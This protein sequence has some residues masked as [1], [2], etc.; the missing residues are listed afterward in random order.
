MAA[1]R[2]LAAHRDALQRQ[3]DA[4]QR[5]LGDL[6]R[7]EEPLSSSS[8]EL[9]EEDD[10]SEDS[11]VQPAHLAELVAERERVQ[12]EI[13]E[14]EHTLGPRDPDDG[15]EAAAATDSSE[16]DSGEELD[17]PHNVETCL[18]MNLVYQE[19][20]KE[21][22]V[23]LE[24]LLLDNREQQKKVMAQITG[25]VAPQPSSSAMSPYSIY[26]GH[27]MKPYFKDKISSLGPPPN[28]ETRD[29]M[30]KGSM[31][32]NDVKIKRWEGWH[33]TLLFNA[34]V[35]DTMKR[36]LQPK[37]SK[38]EYLTKKMSKASDME[39]QILQKQVG[40]IEREI[41]DINAMTTDQLVGNRHDDHDWDKISNIDFEGTRNAADIRRF[42]Q[43]C[44]H[45]SVN[46][47]LWKKDE[48]EKLKGIVE[49]YKACHWDQIAEKLGTNRTAFMCLQMYQR[50]INKGFRKSVWSKE[51]DEVLKEL[52]YKM[53]IGNFIPYTQ[54]SYFMEGRDSSQLIYRW[55]QVLDP[56]LRKG[57]WSKEEDELLLKAVAKYGMKDWAKIRTE[58]PGRTDGQCRDRYLDCLKG[59]VK[60]G[61]WSKEEDALL[62]KLVEKHGVGRWAK[63][64][65]ELPNRLDCQCLQRWKAMTGYGKPKRSG[66]RK[67]QR[68]APRKRTRKVKVKV[69]EEEEDM[70]TSEDEEQ[71]VFMDSEEEA[72]V[73]ED[74][75]END[76][77]QYFLPSVEEW[78]PKTISRF[79]Q[80]GQR[81]VR[82]P[83]EDAAGSVPPGRSRLGR[84][85]SANSLIRAEHLTGLRST[86]VDLSGCPLGVVVDSE[87][88][89]QEEENF[90]ENE[91]IKV[92]LREVKGLL[93]SSWSS[94]VI[95]RGAERK[96]GPQGPA[97]HG[98]LL[99]KQQLGG[100]DAPKSRSLQAS[101][102]TRIHSPA[103][104]AELLIAVLPWVGSLLV[105]LKS[106]HLTEAKVVR[107]KVKAIGLT[108]TPVFMLFLKVLCIDAEGCK[109]VIE[110]RRRRR[111]VTYVTLTTSGQDPAVPPVCLK[112]PRKANTHTVAQMLYEKRQR[113]FAAKAPAQPRKSQLFVPCVMV[114]QTVLLKP[115][116]QQPA[117]LASCLP[118][119]PVQPG[120][121][122]PKKRLH[123][124]AEDS[125]PLDLATKRARVKTVYPRPASGPCVPQGAA[126]ALSGSVTWIVTPNGLL[127]VS[128]LGALMPAVTQTAVKGGVSPGGGAAAGPLPLGASANT[129]AGASQQVTGVSSA[130]SAVSPPALSPAAPRSSPGARA[131][132]A[133]PTAAAPVRPIATP[134]PFVPLA[135]RLPLTTRVSSP[136]ISQRAVTQ[137]QT[138][139]MSL[140]S[141]PSNSTLPLPSPVDQTA[142]P[143][144]AH[145]QPVVHV[146]Q[147]GA[148]VTPVPAGGRSPPRAVRLLQPGTSTA[149]EP[150]RPAEPGSKSKHIGFDPNLMFLEEESQVREWMKGTGGVV[151]PQLDSTLPYLPPFVSN[152]ATLADLLQ[153]KSSLE[154]SALQL[155]D[156]GEQVA[157]EQDRVDA[158]RALVA[159]R[160]GGNPAY[161]LL[162]ARFLACFTLPA[163]L[164]T[165]HPH[166][167]QWPPVL[168]SHENSD[169]EDGVN[170]EAKADSKVDAKPC[171][172][173]PLSTDGEGREAPQFSGMLTR[174][175]SRIAQNH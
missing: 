32:F 135:V 54:I 134:V 35:K 117:P 33:K 6:G 67:G 14:L 94:R 22:L 49:E 102:T 13:E 156:Q 69:E 116:V 139:F 68:R 36:L 74:E 4:L 132:T 101:G 109:K 119:A 38:L 148:S 167:R 21:K 97:Q 5:S 43:N 78:I 16:E 37:I 86:V 88:Q 168:S 1:Q 82:V 126:A 113:E 170:M 106:E 17:L 27:F 85:P 110:E 152:L 105:P 72:P 164:A 160:F 118:A 66:W 8:S 63:I 81:V 159:E 149:T 121:I 20:L 34:V 130:P 169:G 138:G 30:S 155:L 147:P 145:S 123:K 99:S 165:V 64:S 158:V 57:H 42:W 3:I 150:Q 2:R 163:F 141:V 47:S 131:S 175:R 79:P 60:K 9:S 12:K 18:Q 62:I 48:I 76:T 128:G 91:L 133:A 136:Q 28:S 115:A 25:P 100:P 122:L 46:K 84:I 73:K 95:Q 124:P 140:V 61:P 120:A 26:L 111:A 125:E 146:V 19:V 80:F 90:S 154:M 144:G 103:L 114:P 172:S 45:P 51:E 89:P 127:P 31:S 75:E 171:Q 53:R 29:K 77:K 50:Y 162:K 65:T 59:G 96:G 174:R 92:S 98:T 157:E 41:E 23:E 107:E 151:L 15:G 44:L 11:E 129:A 104:N 142:S 108:S 71:L 153:R 173:T 39:K 161:L 24:R 93:G 143:A 55:T 40:Q 70:S 7:G 56:T 10:G 87:L 166:R 58:V 83:Q 137:A 112:K 52:V